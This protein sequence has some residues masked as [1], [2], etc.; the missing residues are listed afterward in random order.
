MTRIMTN[1]S[2]INGQR[3]LARTGLKMGKTLEKLASGYRINRAADDAA[4]LAISE[5]M[6]AQIRGNTQ[7][8][9]NAQARQELFEEFGA[10]DS[11]QV[12]RL[13]G[14]TAKNRSATASRWVA[15]G[16]LFAIQHRGRRYYPAFQFD[17]NG[18]PRPAIMRVLEALRPF[19]LDG[20]E[21]ALW[22]TTATGWLD[23]RR[24]VDLLDA[25][26]DGVVA[27]AGVP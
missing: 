11:E 26:A 17:D 4:G 22:F 8:L 16:Q 12:A 9:R 14:S 5:K 18:R 21:I 1:V 15:S 7:A 27:A 6:R 19:G 23:D 3:N 13:A 20:W 10:L 24:P 25:D 2:A